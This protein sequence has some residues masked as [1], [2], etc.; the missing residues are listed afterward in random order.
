VANPWL[1]FSYSLYNYLVI[2]SR[3]QHRGLGVFFFPQYFCLVANECAPLKPLIL[4]Y[5]IHSGYFSRLLI[6]KFS[7][8]NLPKNRFSK[9]NLKLIFGVRLV[10]FVGPLNVGASVDKRAPALRGFRQQTSSG[11]CLLSVYFL[12][13]LCGSNL[14][15]HALYITLQEKCAKDK[16]ACLDFQSPSIILYRDERSHIFT[17]EIDFLNRNGDDNEPPMSHISSTRAYQETYQQPKLME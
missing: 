13:S 2:Y 12:T 16:W 6:N 10:V 8:Q 4:M 11:S 15:V 17:L 5:R 9:L 7:K 1:L 3:G 14:P